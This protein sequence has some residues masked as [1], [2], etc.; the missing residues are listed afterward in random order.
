VGWGEGRRGEEVTQRRVTEG[1]FLG[2]ISFFPSRARLSR[3]L[4]FS[5]QRKSARRRGPAR[6]RAA[7]PNS[8]G[9]WPRAV[10]RLSRD[11]GGANRCERELSMAGDACPPA[12]LQP[13]SSACITNAK[14]ST[15]TI[16]C[17][18]CWPSVCLLG[19]AILYSKE[20]AA[21][22]GSRPR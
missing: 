20:S 4:G 8:E 21:R 6:N 7:R 15:I 16:V 9:S 2:G 3:R 12:L 17:S 5:G 11:G 19:E 1:I 10:S 18:T 22:R 14:S 13:R